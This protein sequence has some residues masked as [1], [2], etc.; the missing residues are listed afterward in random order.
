VDIRVSRHCIYY[1]SRNN[2]TLICAYAARFAFA[3]TRLQD[4]ISK[5]RE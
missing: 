1:P 4:R 5:G 2:S 3:M